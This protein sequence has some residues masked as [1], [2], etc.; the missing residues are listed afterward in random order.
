MSDAEYFT[1]RAHQEINAALN[2]A[3]RRVRDVHLELADAY[4]FRLRE[5]A[6]QQLR[7]GSQL[8]DAA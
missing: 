8:V 4:A 5:M 6:R 1:E 2:A 3:D 7:P